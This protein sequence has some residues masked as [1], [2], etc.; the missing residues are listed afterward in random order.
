MSLLMYRLMQDNDGVLRNILKTPKII[1]RLLAA[2]KLD[3]KRNREHI[4][5]LANAHDTNL[6]DKDTRLLTELA[7]KRIIFSLQNTEVTPALLSTS[8][9]A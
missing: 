2:A 3:L 7:I 1:P 6:D 9:D 8:V 4:L 5:L